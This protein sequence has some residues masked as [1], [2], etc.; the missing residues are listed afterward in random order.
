MKIFSLIL[1]DYNRYFFNNIELSFVIGKIN[2]KDVYISGRSL[3]KYHVANIL[4]QLGGG[5]DQMGGAC[6]IEN[7]SISKVEQ[8]LL[9]VLKKEG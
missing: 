7:S 3:G 9:Q 4:E 5:G 8:K 1:Q 2:E 6:R